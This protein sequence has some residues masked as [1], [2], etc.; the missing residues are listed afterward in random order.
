MVFSLA[1]SPWAFQVDYSSVR[2]TWVVI[3]IEKEN[4]IGAQKENNRAEKPKRENRKEDAARIFISCV[5]FSA[6]F[7]AA[8]TRRSAAVCL[9]RAAAA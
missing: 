6:A 4:A 7:S 8:P 1:W 3:G 9:R 5:L 2:S